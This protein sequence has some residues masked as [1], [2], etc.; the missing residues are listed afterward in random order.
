MKATL[1]NYHL[2]MQRVRDHI[3][4][5]LDGDLHLEAVS[6][7]AAF[8]NGHFNGSSRRLSGR[9]YTAMSSSP[10]KRASYRLAYRDA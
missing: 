6:G 2:R 8:S 9:P 3:D 7:V 5:H 4:Q 10:M 1:E